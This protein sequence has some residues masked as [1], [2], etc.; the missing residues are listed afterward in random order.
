M[1]KIKEYTATEMLEEA[2][3]H[4]EIMGYESREEYY[5]NIILSLYN[6]RYDWKEENESVSKIQT[7][8]LNYGLEMYFPHTGFSVVVTEIT[9]K[10][11]NAHDK[12]LIK[13]NLEIGKIYEVDGFVIRGYYSKITLKGFGYF[14]NSS[15]FKKVKDV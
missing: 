1:K 11:G 3:S 2:L 5:Q 13:D 12:D 8:D 7:E 10:N 6:K 14:F 4:Y 9:A 15:N